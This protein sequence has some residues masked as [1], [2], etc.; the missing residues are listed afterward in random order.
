MANLRDVAELAGVSVATASRV[1]SGSVAVRAETRE[2]AMRELLYVPPGRERTGV[3]GL[4]VP[5]LVNPVFPALAQAMEVRAASL[6][7][8]SILC[9]TQGSTVA[10]TDYVHMLLERHVDGMVFISCEGADLDADH[11]HYRR[12]REEGARLV[13]VNGAV[14]S[15]DAPSVGVD[16]VAAGQ[17]ATQHLLDLG[18]ER[19]GFVAGPPQ[20][21][22]TREKARGRRRALRAAGIADGSLVAYG[23]F[24]VEGGRAAAREL[25][26]AAERPTGMI[27]ASDVMAIGALQAAAAAGL[28][29]PEDVS[30]VGFDGIDAGR[31]TRP[32][33]TTVEQ[34][35]DEIAE[36]AID[37]LRRLIEDPDRELPA[38]RFRP[39]LVVR[40]STAPIP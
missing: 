29:V 15:L 11:A 19:I 36:V 34:P 28:R 24:A 14:A 2:R 23:D 13:F 10:E 33:L 31:W 30:I 18:H 32:T 22:P 7:Y 8:A 35:I 37:A 26:E 3:I 6:G 21:L 40:E 20:F 4:L 27:C 25:L 39:R 12:L 17:L 5:E 1:A 38:F 9:N 16:E